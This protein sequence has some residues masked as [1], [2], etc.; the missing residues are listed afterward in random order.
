MPRE[1]R[2]VNGR[3][4][5]MRVFTGRY[6]SA[7]SAMQIAENHWVIA[8]TRQGGTTLFHSDHAEMHDLFLRNL[9]VAD[10]D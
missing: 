5:T 10:V 6:V 9:E 2:E 4:W 3:V 8:E 1:E 7:L